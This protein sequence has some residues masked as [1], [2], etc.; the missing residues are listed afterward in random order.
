[1][2]LIGRVER[3]KLLLTRKIQLS[4][5]DQIAYKAYARPFQG[6][7][8]AV[9]F[10]I[11]T[12]SYPVGPYEIFFQGDGGYTWKLMEKAP[13]IFYNLVTYHIASTS[14]GQ[15]SLDIPKTVKVID[16]FGSHEIPVEPWNEPT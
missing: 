4:H 15:P 10:L 14:P 13:E 3:E 8:S 16:G 1:M 5:A 7:A 6:T 9:L 2:D 12:C 11:A